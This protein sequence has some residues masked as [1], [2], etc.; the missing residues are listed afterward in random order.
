MTN[1][2]DARLREVDALPTPALDPARA[3]EIQ[4]L[5]RAQFMETDVRSP[6]SPARGQTPGNILV[7][8]LL[9]ACTLGY[10]AWTAQTLSALQPLEREL[11]RP[12]GR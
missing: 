12:A 9:C 8:A 7:G 2:E 3:R 11:S 1:T 6:A 10:L 5:A 4:R